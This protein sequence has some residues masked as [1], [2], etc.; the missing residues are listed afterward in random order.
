M[1]YT[2]PYVDDPQNFDRVFLT[3]GAGI[4]AGNALKFDVAYS[5]CL[6]IPSQNY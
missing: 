1:Y 2:S 4:M 3:A 6:L 5:C